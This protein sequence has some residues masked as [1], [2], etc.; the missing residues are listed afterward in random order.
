MRGSAAACGSDRTARKVHRLYRCAV[1]VA[2]GA[3]LLSGCATGAYQQGERAARI[4]DWDAAVAFYGRAL[5][6]EP[7]RADVRIALERTKQRAIWGHLDIAREL[8]AG[9][10]LTAA[11]AEYQQALTYDP[12]NGRAIDRL[13][14]IEREIRERK[15]ASLPRRHAVAPVGLQPLTPLLDPSSQEPLHIQFRDASLKDILNFIGDA[16]GI[17]VVYDE[18]FQDRSYSVQL[19]GVTLEEALDV[20]L[21]ANQYFY[22]V[23]YPRAIRV[24]SGTVSR[25]R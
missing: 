10:E 5:Q 6:E 23:L 7:D 14:A 3:G 4:G 11:Q 17:A 18:Q 25:A 24:T 12:S 1:V 13:T 15:T 21:T 2:L 20:I 9:D 8:E 16:A 19:D 22:K